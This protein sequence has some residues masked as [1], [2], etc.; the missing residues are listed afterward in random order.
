MYFIIFFF[1]VL[2]SEIDV[3]F[4]YELKYGNGKQVTIQDT[5]DYNYLE[6]LLDINTSFSNNMYLYTQL[7]YSD[8]PVF[9]DRNNKLALLASKFRR[10]PPAPPPPFPFSHLRVFWFSC[11][12]FLAVSALV[13]TVGGVAYYDASTSRYDH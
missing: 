11:C 10:P 3:S 5:S 9:G 12:N 13:S 4:S 1:G 8:P 6:N 2:F 7:E